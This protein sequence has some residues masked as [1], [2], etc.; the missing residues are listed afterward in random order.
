MVS[1]VK[2]TSG[3]VNVFVICQ[4][5]QLGLAFVVKLKDIENGPLELP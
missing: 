5:P 4:K 2:A 3:S 1:P